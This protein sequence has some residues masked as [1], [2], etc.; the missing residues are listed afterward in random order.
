MVHVGLAKQPH[1]CKNIWTSFFC[2]TQ[3]S[4][5]S[6]H[7]EQCPILD[8]LIYYIRPCRVNIHMISFS[9]HI[10]PST[11]RVAVCSRRQVRDGAQTKCSIRGRSYSSTGSD[12]EYSAPS[13]VATHFAVQIAPYYLLFEYY[14]VPHKLINCRRTVDPIA[15]CDHN[16]CVRLHVPRD[17]SLIVMLL[18]LF[19]LR[20]QD[21][22]SPFLTSAPALQLNFALAI[23]ATGANKPCVPRRMAFN[24]SPEKA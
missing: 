5:K 15:M 16:P 12:L 11:W 14:L 2:F 24:L 23:G 17:T 6:N 21:Q 22:P 18:L 8:L 1:M 9:S 4:Q 13:S 19:I 10:L 20:K 7:C 3:F